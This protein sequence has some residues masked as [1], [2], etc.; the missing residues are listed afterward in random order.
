MA[1]SKE[2]KTGDNVSASEKPKVLKFVKPEMEVYIA[3]D[4]KLPDLP[5]VARDGYHDEWNVEKKES[6]CVCNKVCTCNL[7][8]NCSCVGNT[9]S[10][11]CV[12]HTSRC[13]CVSHS[14]GCSCV[15]YRSGGGGGSR[16]VCTCVPVA[17]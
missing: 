1:E 17:H 12:R 16:R 14:K 9:A 10:C 8:Q 4:K 13:S 3:D 11:S 15:S 2:K 6:V 7:V 5:K